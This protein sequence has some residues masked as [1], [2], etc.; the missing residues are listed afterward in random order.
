MSHC[1]FTGGCYLYAWRRPPDPMTGPSAYGRESS[2]LLVL[3]IGTFALQYPREIYLSTSDSYV[4]VCVV[5]VRFSRSLTK[6]KN[7][8]DVAGGVTGDP[9]WS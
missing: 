2:P 7:E 9:T 1:H 5:A 3:E 4:V 6:K 8:T